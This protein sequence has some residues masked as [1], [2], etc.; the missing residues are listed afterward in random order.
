MI[1]KWPQ[2]QYSVFQY[3]DNTEYQ[4]IGRSLMSRYPYLLRPKWTSKTER[5]SNLFT[6]QDWIPVQTIFK[7][8][9]IQYLVFQYDYN[10]EYQFIGC[11]LMSRYPNPLRPKWTSKTGRLSNLFTYQDWN[12]DQMI[13]K[14]PQNQYS[15]FQYN[16]NTE[17]QFIGRFL[18]SMYPNPLRPKWTSKTERIPNL[19]HTRIETQS[20]R[21]LNGLKFNI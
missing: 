12:P 21:S 13:S 6:Y 14:W 18:K 19:L 20:K 4:F 1:Y 17:Y 11:S 5:I 9:E 2:I 3:D 7:W 8:P 10:T 16:D 15:V